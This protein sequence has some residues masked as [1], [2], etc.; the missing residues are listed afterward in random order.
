MDNDLF[1]GIMVRDYRSAVQ[2]YER[3][4]GSAP[5]FF[6]NEIEAV[7][8]IAEHRYLYI[9]QVPERAGYGRTMIGIAEV[10]ARIAEL[11]EHGFDP[12]E[13]EEHEGVRKII[14]RDPDG[15]EISYGG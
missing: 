4:L 9:E 10:E 3:F 1:A 15:N 8:E 11:A 7:W 13:V 6:P 12:A 5:A 2:W 14:Y